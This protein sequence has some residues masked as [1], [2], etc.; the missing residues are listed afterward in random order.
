MITSG[1]ASPVTI[2]ALIPVGAEVAQVGVAALAP[3]KAALESV[4]AS[5]VA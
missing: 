5:N 2:L 4:G 3:I 1:S